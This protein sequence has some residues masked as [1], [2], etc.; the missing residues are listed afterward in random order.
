[1]FEARETAG[2]FFMIRRRH[3]WFRENAD[4]GR[5]KRMAG[6]VR[7]NWDIEVIELTPI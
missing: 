7:K 3:L 4:E 2:G 1:L 6:L 5:R